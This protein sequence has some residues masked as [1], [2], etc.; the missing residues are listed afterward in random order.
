MAG[1]IPT[2]SARGGSA[3][4]LDGRPKRCTGAS[5]ETQRGFAW[6]QIG[7]RLA[8]PSSELHMLRN[9]VATSTVR[10]GLLE[11]RATLAK[12]VKTKPTPL[13]HT[14]PGLAGPT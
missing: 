6:C 9:S 5:C 7:G 11:S 3:R 13:G 1:Q 10:V 12:A 4:R 14:R 2:V 8:V